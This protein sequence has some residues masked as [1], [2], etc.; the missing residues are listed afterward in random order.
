V[1]E[2]GVEVEEVVE[3]EGAV[4]T[5]ADRITIETAPIARMMFH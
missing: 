1:G 4:P 2:D 5:I 3:V